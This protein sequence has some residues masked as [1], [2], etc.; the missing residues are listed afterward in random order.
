MK[1]MLIFFIDVYQILISPLKQKSCRFYPTCS[2]YSKEAITKFGAVKGGYLSIKRIIS[3]NPLNPGG[4]DLVPEKFSFR[5][6]GK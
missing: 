4:I 2:E 1:K 5:R 3:C 6:R